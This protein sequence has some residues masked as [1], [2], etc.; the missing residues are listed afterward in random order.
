MPHICLGTKYHH[1][2]VEA[3]QSVTHDTKLFTLRLPAGSYLEVPTGHHLSV[4]ANVDGKHN[5]C[6]TT[7]NNI[8]TPSLSLIL[9]E[10][11]ER[12]YTPV[13]AMEANL[14]TTQC[15]AHQVTQQDGE[16]ETL[17]LMVKLYNDGKMSKFLSN[18]KQGN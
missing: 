15:H 9:G 10:D 6:N 13:S 8:I 7:N 17:Q 11:V 16:F 1:T 12:S 14:A 2:C 18:L 5:C 4:K 3:I